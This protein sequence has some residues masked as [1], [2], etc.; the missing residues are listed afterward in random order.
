M[1]R[2]ALQVDYRPTALPNVQIRVPEIRRYELVG[3][4]G[5]WIHLRGPLPARGPEDSG[6]VLPEN[7]A[8]QEI[9]RADPKDP[10]SMVDLIETLG[11]DVI[12][13]DRN[14]WRDF[15]RP[16]VGELNTDLSGIYYDRVAGW[17]EQLDW[18][19]V[20]YEDLN[21]RDPAKLGIVKVHAAEVSYRVWRLQSI[22]RGLAGN[23]PVLNEAR[24]NI[25]FP[26]PATWQHPS[27]IE[28]AFALSLQPFSPLVALT[29]TLAH[30]DEE[31]RR[32]HPSGSPTAF[33][34]AVLQLYNAIARGETFKKCR[35]CQNPFTSQVGRSK[36]HV[37]RVRR[38]SDAEFCSPK[39]QKALEQRD[40]RAAAKHAKLAS[41]I[42][43]SQVME[44]PL[45]KK[46][47]SHD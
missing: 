46:K 5:A 25:D 22:V 21:P 42:Q 13:V 33:E 15:L 36:A 34:V 16:I 47:G 41:H 2:S 38:R 1:T 19:P 23:I 26:E 11:G 28:E 29:P 9:L 4:E 39:C 10:Q 35:N 8:E 14:R 40:R 32:V 44:A 43:E 30:A 37:E 12:A 20:T 3:L 27:V 7:A 24:N 45:E 31:L 18:G 17:S 6:F